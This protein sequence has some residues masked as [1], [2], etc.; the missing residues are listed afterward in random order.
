MGYKIVKVVGSDKIPDWQRREPKWRDLED[1]VMKLKPGESLEVYFDDAKV[2][3]RARNAVRDNANLHAKSIVVRTRIL[4]SGS[5]EGATVWLT[6]VHPT[7]ATVPD[8]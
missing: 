8:N 2:A 5:K 1:A 3:E 4:T 7:Q 6:R